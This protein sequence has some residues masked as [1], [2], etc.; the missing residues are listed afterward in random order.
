MMYPKLMLLE[1]SIYLYETK[2]GPVAYR[3][4]APEHVIREFEEINKEHHRIV[5][6][7]FIT[8]KDKYPEED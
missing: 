6:K 8:I 7:D 2:N 1:Y 4:E 3:D 5:G